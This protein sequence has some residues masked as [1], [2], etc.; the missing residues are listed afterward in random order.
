MGLVM[1]II[2]GWISAHYRIV[3]PPDMHLY[4]GWIWHID[5]GLYRWA[6]C[7]YPLY[8]PPSGYAPVYASPLVG[9]YP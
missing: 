7:T 1:D 4:M 2:R 5:M 6:I 8:A 3:Y 9:G